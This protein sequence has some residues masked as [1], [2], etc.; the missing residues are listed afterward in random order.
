MIWEIDI[1]Q[2]SA[3]P[4]FQIL[5]ECKV[6][7]SLGLVAR[8]PWAAGDSVPLRTS[9]SLPV[10]ISPGGASKKAWGRRFHITSNVPDPTG[11]TYQQIFPVWTI[12]VT[13]NQRQLATATSDNRINLWCL[14]THQLLAPLIGHA[15]TIW[16]L[17]YSPDDLLLAST[18]ADGTVRLWENLS[19]RGRVLLGES[20]LQA[21]L[22]QS[23][24]TA[25]AQGA[26][27]GDVNV[28]GSSSLDKDV[29]VWNLQMTT[30]GLA[31]NEQTE[32]EFV[33]AQQQAEAMSEQVSRS[34]K[35]VG[36][37]TSSPSEVTEA[38]MRLQLQYQENFADYCVALVFGRAAN[39]METRQTVTAF[40]TSVSRGTLVLVTLK[41]EVVPLCS[42]V[43][44][45][46]FL[47]RCLTP[48]VRA[49]RQVITDMQQA[50]H[51][52]TA[53]HTLKDNKMDVAA[54]L[55]MLCGQYEGLCLMLESKVP[56]LAALLCDAQHNSQVLEEI[57]AKKARRS[58]QEGSARTPSRPSRPAA[59]PAGNHSVT[60]RPSLTQH[61][62]TGGG[63]S[64]KQ[65]LATLRRR[66]P[67]ACIKWEIP[68]LAMEATSRRSG[69]SLQ[70]C[71]QQAPSRWRHA[72]RATCGSSDR[73]PEQVGSLLLDLSREFSCCYFLLGLPRAFGSTS[74]EQTCLPSWLMQ[75]ASM[76]CPSA[77][78]STKP[79]ATCPKAHLSFFW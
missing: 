18:S 72:S 31:G 79:L 29:A 21:C 43:A 49:L 20:V 30:S 13:K 52:K 22:E 11:E 44:Q 37:Y 19:A 55:Q 66:V 36:W 53:G 67:G 59:A 2:T 39:A 77:A 28:N 26:L 10:T 16:R 42:L 68:R 9:D 48:T 54:E 4:S 32:E 63:D 57:F 38:D 3:D 47:Q 65:H 46:C 58:S 1:P 74:L 60:A 64:D 14:V 15:D 71:L 75:T 5:T 76:R 12:A 56:V 33:A 41:V 78:P 23:R 51:Q 35:V 62:D 17:A 8:R 40:R 69:W 45:D 27:F 6:K 50:R 7:Q 61:P 34:T 25:K 24:L 73:L 70:G